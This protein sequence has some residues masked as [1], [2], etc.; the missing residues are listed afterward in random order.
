MKYFSSLGIIAIAIFSFY[1]TEKIA[2]LTLQ[3]N[4]IYQ[5]ILENK[6]TYEV[7][8]VNAEVLGDNVTPGLNGKVVD[9]KTSFFNM[10]D[11]NAFN[12]YYLVYETTYPEE[13]L[14]KY[15]DK[16]INK[17]NL[18]KHE[19]SFVLEYDANTI[20]FF[21]DNNIDASILVDMNTF[22]KSEKL[23]QLNADSEK[24]DKLDTL[25]N[26]YSKNSNIC[27]VNNLIEEKCRDNNKFLVK[28]EKNVNK[29]N[30]INIKKNIASGDI[31]YVAKNTELADI[32]IL[33]NNIMY[34]DLDIVRLSELL[35]E[36]RN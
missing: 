24:Y 36:E 21:K 10:K 25:L 30:L 28:S 32:K 23:E 11:I 13:S 2:D 4:D 6:D 18:E 12:T 31:Y 15:K 14:T 22:N 35:S 1:Y 17:G 34:K 9:V 19:V 26:K 3:K 8:P 20:K 7:K 5:M 16:I 33:I 27:Y 29:S